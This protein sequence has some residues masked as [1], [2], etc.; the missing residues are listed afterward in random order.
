MK[1]FL[2]IIS[3]ILVHSATLAQV[4]IN[5]PTP[6]AMLDVMG[7]VKVEQKLYLEN[8]GDYDEI[9]GSKLLIQATDKAILQYDIEKSKYGPINYAEYIFRDT[10]TI[11]LRDYDTQISASEYFV[12]VQGYYFLDPNGDTNITSHSTLNTENIEGFQIYAYIDSATNTWFIRAFLNNG[13]FQ[14]NATDTQIDLY[15]N[16]IIYRNEFISKA[17]NTITIDMDDKETATAPLPAGF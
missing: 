12:T 3:F 17:L 14:R 2:Y 15:L 11:G 9:R 4:G 13:T 6:T 1:K 5:T 8:P 10:M 7:D 16:L